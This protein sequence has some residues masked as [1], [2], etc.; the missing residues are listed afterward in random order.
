[1]KNGRTSFLF[2]IIILNNIN[3]NYLNIISKQ[4]INNIEFL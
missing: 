1:M 3:Y 2:K 4:V